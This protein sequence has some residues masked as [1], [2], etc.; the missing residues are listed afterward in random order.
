M[1]IS[2]YFEILK[3]VNGTCLSQTVSELR[4][5]FEILYETLYEIELPSTILF[6]L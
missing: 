1:A 3:G 5:I 2:V 4:T 6:K